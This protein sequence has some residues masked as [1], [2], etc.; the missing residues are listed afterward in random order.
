VFFGI[1]GYP[2][3]F[4]AHELKLFEL[5][6]EKPLTCDE[7]AEAKGIARRPA[8]GGRIV[9]HAM[10]FNDSRTGPFRVAAFN[11]DILITMPGQQ[12][13]GRELRLILKA[14]GFGK[15]QVKRTVGYWSIVT[16]VKP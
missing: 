12:Y 10:L 15:I 14:A 8:T 11:V 6:S 13:S 5:L 9:V 7:V 4:V 16:G 1:W 2:A 3:V